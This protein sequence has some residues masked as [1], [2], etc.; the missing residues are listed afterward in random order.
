LEALYGDFISEAARLLGYGLTHRSGD[1]TNLVRLV[2]MIVHMRLVSDRSVIDAARLAERT[3]VQTYLG[4]DRT[5][6]ELMDFVE[7]GS[8]DFLTEFGEACRKDL[9]ARATAIR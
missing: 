1:I 9:A 7:Q 5:L 2:A 8:A 3:I 6:P 4:P